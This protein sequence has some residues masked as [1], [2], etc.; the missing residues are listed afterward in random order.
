MQQCY[1]TVTAWTNAGCPAHPILQKATLIP[2]ALN[3]GDSVGWIEISN[4][5]ADRYGDIIKVAG[6]ELTNYR[7]NPVV[8]FGHDYHNP[9][10]G[11][12]KELRSDATRLLMVP[13]FPDRETYAFG[14]CCGELMRKGFLNAASVG[15]SPLTWAYDEERMGYDFQTQ[16]LLEVSLCSV[17]ANPLCLVEAR[18]AGVDLAPMAA[19]ADRTLQEDTFETLCYTKPQLERLTKALGP[20]R[21]ISIPRLGAG[22]PQSLTRASTTPMVQ[23]RALTAP[24]LQDLLTPLQQLTRVSALA[25]HYGSAAA[26]EEAA[27]HEAHAAL[28]QQHGALRG[29]LRA[30]T[31]AQRELTQ[32]LV[33]M[34][35]LCQEGLEGLLAGVD[36]LEGHLAALCGGLAT[37]A[38]ACHGSHIQALALADGLDTLMQ[39]Q[40]H[41]H[42]HS[43]AVHDEA[44]TLTQ[45][46]QTMIRQAQATEALPVDLPTVMTEPLS[47]EPPFLV[48]EDGEEDDTLDMDEARAM[49]LIATVLG[50]AQIGA[51]V[52][53]GIRAALGRVD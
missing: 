51:Q 25:L 22:W 10:I 23:G 46:Q 50:E 36:A 47:E 11:R 30:M 40:Q 37:V 18:S 52:Q 12:A 2:A 7:A 35:E 45:R 14:A 43:T 1:R 29:G 24:E 17:P 32:L 26:E 48:L 34:R 33:E 42:Q 20:Q 3:A 39:T 21:T 49:A 38:E 5:T 41:W 6:W 9:P 28:T 4:E 15:F 19:W 31:T 8:L 27:L 13:E 16:E 44:Q 53:A